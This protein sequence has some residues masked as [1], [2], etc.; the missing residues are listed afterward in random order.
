VDVS[1]SLKS[2]RARMDNG[3]DKSIKDIELEGIMR[4]RLLTNF[5]NAYKEK[6]F[7]SNSTGDAKGNMDKEELTLAD[8]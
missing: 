7:L 2:R 6:M 1:D 5:V 3:A 8:L 4:Y